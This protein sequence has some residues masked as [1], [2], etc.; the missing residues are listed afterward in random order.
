MI[1]KGIGKRPFSRSYV[2]WD[3]IDCL[4]KTY[5]KLKVCMEEEV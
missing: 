3:R 1:G 2:R 4:G 5:L